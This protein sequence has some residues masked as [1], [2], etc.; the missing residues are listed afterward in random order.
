MIASI[1]YQP[2]FKSATKAYNSKVKVRSSKDRSFGQ[3]KNRS[4]ERGK[5]L[6]RNARTLA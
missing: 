4:K 5:K 3:S 2:V 1:H 6:G